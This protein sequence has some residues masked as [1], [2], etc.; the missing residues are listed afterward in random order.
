[1]YDLGDEQAYKCVLLEFLLERTADRPF[2]YPFTISLFVYQKMGSKEAYSPAKINMAKNPLQAIERIQQAM[3]SLETRFKIFNNIQDIKNKLASVKNQVRLLRARINTW[4]VKIRS[5]VESPLMIT[6]QLIGTLTDLGGVV[7]DAY[8]Q[9]KLTIDTWVNAKETIHDQIRESLGIYG[10]LIQEG[11]Q[12]TSD[13]TMPKRTGMDFTDALNPLPTSTAESYSYVGINIYIVKAHD[14]LQS[15]AQSQLG[16]ANLWPFIAA[17]NKTITSN[18]D[19]Y[20]GLEIYV[21][22]STTSG[23]TEKDGFILTED[24]LRNPYGT[25]IRVDAN[26]DIVVFESND[27]AT[28]SGEANVLQAIDL[29]LKTEVGSMITQTAYG[30]VS[31]PGLSGTAQAVSYVRM[32]LIDALMKDPRIAQVK[33]VRVIIERDSLKC[34]AE[35][36]LVGYEKSIPASVILQ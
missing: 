25:D 29:R 27:V 31:Q 15:I 14:T 32:N 23:G 1:M 30:L 3:D 10:F 17:V 2:H 8:T 24:V 33:N 13:Q 36:Y 22:V 11:A 34:S 6:K 18:N 21:P 12:Q 20:A 7:Y 5:V 4:L 28:I 26:G 16:A 19:L 9:G 35:I